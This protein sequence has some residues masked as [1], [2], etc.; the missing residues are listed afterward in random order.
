MSG[1]PTPSRTDPPAELGTSGA[2]GQPA[3]HAS[4]PTP[5][6]ASRTLEE[7]VRRARSLAAPGARR[8]LGIAGPPGAGKSTL[9]ASL[10]EALG[11]RAALVGLDGFHLANAELVRLGR[12]DRKGAPDTFD[13]FGYL[14]LLRRLLERPTEVVYA[15]RYTRELEEPIAGAVPVPPEVDLIVTE[16]NYLLLDNRPWR[17][18][19]DLLAETWYLDLDDATRVERL[20]ARHVRFGKTPAEAA[21]WVS[22]SDEANARLVAATRA[23]AD[24]VVRLSRRDLPQ[25]RGTGTA[26]H[27][28]VRSRGPGS[29]TP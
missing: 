17:F 26:P 20:V 13:A 6:A 11:P 7:L 22:R 8:L 29:A 5:A 16:G 24:L 23:H 2:P 21:A 15:P 10:V 3:P 19:R 1:L 4:P 14:A 27:E 18:L 9:A 28:A 25:P 12:R